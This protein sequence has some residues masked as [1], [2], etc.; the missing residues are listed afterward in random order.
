MKKNRDEQSC[1]G[2]SYGGSLKLTLLVH[3][4][5]EH[6]LW[7]H[8]QIDHLPEGLLKVHVAESGESLE[9]LVALGARCV[10]LHAVPGVGGQCGSR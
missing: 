6:F 2:Y 5:P 10:P 1:G 7:R 4:I 9:E 8:E 3:E